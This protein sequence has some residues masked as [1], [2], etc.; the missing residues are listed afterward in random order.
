MVIAVLG[1]FGGRREPGARRLRRVDRDTLDGV[2]AGLGV[3]VEVPDGDDVVTLRLSRMEDFH[4]DVFVHRLP[5]LQALL[6]ARQ[7][8]EPA[9]SQG[10]PD[11]PS[12]R[13][14]PPQR[15][16]PPGP[17]LAPAGASLLDTILAGSTESP[18]RET[19]QELARRV[20]E[21]STVRAPALRARD[22][23][24]HIAERVR[25]VL[26]APRFQALE[27]AWRGLVALVQEAET[28]DALRIYVLDAARDE[29]ALLLAEELA[30]PGAPRPTCV[31]AAYR[32]GTSDYDLAVLERFGAVALAGGAPL[33]GD[34]SPDVLGLDD[35]RQ[36]GDAHVRRRLGL[37]R[38]PDAWRAFRSW[39]AATNVTLCLPRVLLRAPY[40]SAGEQ[41][42]G[43]RF[44]EGLT[45]RQHE[46][47]L[48]GHAALAYGR[49][50]V[51]AFAAQRWEAE[52]DRYATL[53][54]LP[55]HVW[56]EGGEECVLPCAEVVMSDATAAR[57]VEEGV[58][59]V[60]SV[61]ATDRV[62]MRRPAVTP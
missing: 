9:A 36:L 58:L 55:V 15:L 57:A 51:R 35:P 60:A 29:A 52:L 22:A 42:T 32:F 31:L 27:A 38:G 61:R 47:F 18:A 54:G 1:D 45:G 12:E 59:V 16:A 62:E 33:F 40:G 14:P 56:R 4:P 49:V 39:P 3:A 17:L 20:A 11:A 7:A 44:D 43:F 25:A 23:D 10:A 41:V 28:G 53:D 24:P 30:T 21:P 34:A 8:P 2:L 50:L 13:E 6:A 5:G 26:Y 19:I 37:G 46:R 48:W